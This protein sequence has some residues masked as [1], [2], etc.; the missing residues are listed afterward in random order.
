MKKKSG[1]IQTAFVF[2]SLLEIFNKS[3]LLTSFEVVVVVV[4]VVVLKKRAGKFKLLTLQ[5]QV[6]QHHGSREIWPPP[7]P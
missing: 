4:V 1:E 7:R 5:G 6:H 3:S 2:Q